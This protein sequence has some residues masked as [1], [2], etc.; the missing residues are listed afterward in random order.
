MFRNSDINAL[1][2]NLP[3]F[4]FRSRETAPAGI[5]RPYLHYYGLDADNIF[6]HPQ[7]GSFHLL[8]RYS[9]AGFHIA[10]QYFSPPP[11]QVRGTAFIVHGYYDHAGIYGHLIKYCLR[12]NLAVVI[13]DL[14]GHG[15]SSGEIASIDSFAQYRE[16]FNE[17]LRMVQRAGLNKRWFAIGQSTGSAIIMDYCLANCA[18]ANRFERIVLLAPLVRPYQWSRGKLLHALLNPFVRTIKR[19]FAINSSNQEFL[20]FIHESDPLQSRR[21][22]VR[23]VGALKRWLEEFEKCSPCQFPVAVVQ[24][25]LDTTVDWRYNLPVIEEKFPHATI[26]MIANARHHIVNESVSIRERMFS[27]L[28]DVLG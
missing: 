14:P 2:E 5:A 11:E 17:C 18:E 10:C 4:D 6:T 3:E 20:R 22:S 23:W 27:I 16:V 19:N 1:R 12:R 26:Y 21:L 24:G 28:D 9:C 25:A 7:P 8:G 15:L 13:F